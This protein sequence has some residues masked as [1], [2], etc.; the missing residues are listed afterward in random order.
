MNVKDDF[1][2]QNGISEYDRYCPFY[3]TS[4]M[5]KNFVAFY[6]GSQRAI[7]TN[8]MTFAQVSKTSKTDDL[9]RSSLI[10]IWGYRFAT[11]LLTL[12]SNS[13]K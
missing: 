6:D 5:L 3:K 4:G 13:L 10:I 9:T 7:E 8:D 11:L 12:C 2:Q 1:L